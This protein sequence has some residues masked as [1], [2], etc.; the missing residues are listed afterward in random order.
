MATPELQRDR[1][2]VTEE[3][4]KP[5]VTEFTP[6][7]IVYTCVSCGRQIVARLTVAGVAATNIQC[8]AT[9]GCEGTMVFDQSSRNGVDRPHTHEWFRP[10]ISADMPAKVADH[11]KRGGLVIGALPDY[12]PF[13]ELRYRLAAALSAV[14]DPRLATIVERAQRG[15]YDE[16][17]SPF[18][19]PI[20][21]IEKDLR[22]QHRHDLADR[23]KAGEWS[24]TQ[25]DHDAALRV[26]MFKQQ[27][28]QNEAAT[29]A[30]VVR[31]MQAARAERRRI[32]G[33]ARRAERLALLERK[34]MKV[35]K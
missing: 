31:E 32:H 18:D 24:A 14:S 16:Y 20:A 2:T 6:R 4:T 21:L 9:V 35:R 30:N 25:D 12:K 17:A 27:A 33:E 7:N 26:K 28:K 13:V 11:I 22:A 1:R 29:P 10:E 5:Q 34:R 15:V 23:A 8:R 3:T 19:E